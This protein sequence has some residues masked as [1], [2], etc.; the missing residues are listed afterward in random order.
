MTICKSKYH[1]IPPRPPP[2]NTAIFK[3]LTAFGIPNLESLV[4]SIKKNMNCICLYTKIKII[5][6]S[7]IG[8]GNLFESI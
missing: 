1:R 3:Y 7:E 8:L 4:M 6:L 5:Y 2:P